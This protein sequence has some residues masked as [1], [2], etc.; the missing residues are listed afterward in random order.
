MTNNLNARVLVPMKV[1]AFVLNAAVCSGKGANEAKIAPITA[2]NYTYLRLD[3]TLLRPDVLDHVDLHHTTPA[4]YNSRFTD[5]GT[6]EKHVNREGVYLHWMLPRPYRAGSMQESDASNVA[7]PTFVDMP[8]RWLVIRSLNKDTVQPASARDAVPQ[9]TAWMVESDRQWELD[10]LGVDVD[11]QVDVSPFISGGTNV[12]LEEQA[13]VFIG[14]KVPLDSWA[15]EQEDVKR[16]RLSLLNSS[17]P[18]FADYQLHNSNVLSIVDTFSYGDDKKLTAATASYYVVGWH[19]SVDDDLFT[20]NGLKS[21]ADRLR[22]LNMVLKNIVDTDKWCQSRDDTRLLCHGALYHVKWNVYSKPQ[23]VLADDYA[24]IL[25]K[26]NS[27]AV[28]TTSL[29]AL[30]AYIAAQRSSSDDDR[31]TKLK[32]LEE[33]I[34]AMQTLLHARDDGVDTRLEAADQVNNWNYSRIDG[35]CM[36]HPSSSD[37]D[38]PNN[39]LNKLQMQ[40]DLI[41]RTQRQT[42]WNLFSLW[43]KCITNSMRD[44]QQYKDDVKAQSDNLKKLQTMANML[45]DNIKDQSVGL[46]VKRSAADH[47]YEQRDPTLLLGGLPSGWPYDFQNKLEVRLDNQTISTASG[48]LTDEWKNFIKKTLPKVPSTLQKAAKSLILEFVAL[49]QDGDGSSSDSS[50]SSASSSDSGAEV[51]PLYHDQGWNPTNDSGTPWRD[52]WGDTQPWFPLFVE[53]EVEYTHIPFDYWSF[54]EHSARLSQEPIIRGGIKDTV[55]LYDQTLLDKRVVSGRTLILP[56]PVLAL[57]T[58]VA[59]I[60]A[61]TQDSDLERVGISRDQVADLKNNIYQLALISAPLSGFHDHLATRALGY[62]VKPNNRL[63]ANELEPIAQAI[64]SDALLTAD[65][66]KSMLTETNPTPYGFLTDFS[67]SDYCPF[68]PLI[69]GQFKFTKVNIVDKFG[70]AI[71][72]IDPT[73]RPRSQ[74][75]PALYPCISDFYEPQANLD[76]ESNQIANTVERDEDGQCR[77][78][79]VPPHINQAIRFNG[80]FVTL[81]DSKTF[82]RPADGANP[83]WGWVVAN[84]ADNGL[85]FFLE[86]GSFYCEVRLGGPDGSS[87]KPMWLP[88]G[89]PTMSGGSELHNLLKRF[90]SAEY[91]RQFAEMVELALENLPAVP[92]TYANYLNAAIGKPLALVNMAWSLEL[93]DPQYANQSSLINSAAKPDVLFDRSWKVKLGDRQRAFD[94]LVAYFNATDQS[95][96]DSDW[97][98]FD[99][100]KFFTYYY[101][102]D[103]SESDSEESNHG[104]VDDGVKNGL[105][106]IQSCN[107][108]EFKPFWIDPLQYR[109]D[110]DPDQLPDYETYFK[111]RCK[112]F[113]AFAALVDPFTPIHAFSSFFPVQALRLPSWTWQSAMNKMTTFFQIGPLIIPGDVPPFQQQ[114]RLQSEYDLASDATIVPNSSVS[115]PSLKLCDWAWL[116]PYNVPEQGTKSTGSGQS[117]T[118]KVL[119]GERGSNRTGVHM[120]AGSGESGSGSSDDDSSDGGPAIAALGLSTLVD[121]RARLEIGPYTAIEGF[122]QLKTPLLRPESDTK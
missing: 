69:H 17:N 54:E 78:V 19:S 98:L 75:I 105:F 6:G 90:K 96:N 101:D 60:I 81:D 13:E 61:D 121:G 14:A 8:S 64:R 106:P 122:L 113:Q 32:E 116:Q 87:K 3:D 24:K 16:A 51:Y 79:Q 93:A 92:N 2:P 12:D 58:L 72:A 71:H 76:D 48:S 62:H 38:D 73:P 103:Q 55:V 56:Q 86:D 120:E 7:A 31:S 82:W 40:L 4:Q 70:Q 99:F 11:L 104:Y 114:Y 97:T 41:N 68:K 44:D 74:E 109:H 83:V 28:G 111:D 25:H 57:Q 49:E 45:Q 117:G 34:F 119:S 42:R 112:K 94:G 39:K 29:D 80:A 115:I 30:L 108:P 84:R 67:S 50:S 102:K 37:D 22:D 46:D 9:I 33:I 35:G 21:R 88:L 100:G 85:Q 118:A 36:F 53:W 43:W 66:L 10:E 1:D 47:F 107:Y 63:S 27:I 95:N 77:Y 65:A 91:L 52:S 5:L 15:G 89:P 20:T 26:A 110:D 23:N 18:L 59:Q